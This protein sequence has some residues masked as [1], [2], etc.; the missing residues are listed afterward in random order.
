MLS[1]S[2]AA[3]EAQNYGVRPIELRVYEATEASAAELEDRLNAL[4]TSEPITFESASAALTADTPAVLDRVAALAKSLAGVVVVVEGHTDSDGGPANNLAL[5]T[6]R[7]Q[8][9]VSAL[10]IRGVPVA[11]LEPVGV[12]SAEPVLVDGEE[13]RAASRRV[14]FVVVS[15]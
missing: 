5:G 4:V 3:S 1:S 8:A 10:A 11:G 13:D 12:G 6:A 14:E 9:V 2:T 15:E 7:A